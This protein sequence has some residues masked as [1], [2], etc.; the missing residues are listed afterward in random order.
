M[1]DNQSIDWAKGLPEAILA[2]NTQQHSVT[3]KAPYEIVF[4]QRLYGERVLF[5]ERQMAEV[6]AEAVDNPIMVSNEIYNLTDPVL[7]NQ[8]VQQNE[9]PNT[10]EEKRQN[11]H[12]QERETA[13]EGS[14]P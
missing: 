7:R 6:L 9:V 2:M 5:T 1:Q 12:S 3:L 4:R 11:I 13:N 14:S 10:A 8:S